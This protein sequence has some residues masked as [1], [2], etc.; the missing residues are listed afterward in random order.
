MMLL[1]PHAQA[2]FSPLAL[3]PGGAHLLSY[4]ADISSIR[5]GS[6]RANPSDHTIWR[7][8]ADP[9]GVS[10]SSCLHGHEKGITF[11][12]FVALFCISYMFCM[13]LL[14]CKQKTKTK[15][16]RCWGMKLRL[17][18]RALALWGKMPALHSPSLLARCSVCMR[19]NS[20]GPAR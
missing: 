4:Q 17:E 13:N 7:S 6:G 1:W 18:H 20:Q 5:S 8:L 2:C 14:L 19:A 15:T 12:V 10:H 3:P 9:G 11:V 16:Q